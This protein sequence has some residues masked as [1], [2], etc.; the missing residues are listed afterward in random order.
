MPNQ[1][2]VI[3]GKKRESEIVILFVTITLNALKKK[4]KKISL[5]GYVLHTN[6]FISSI[7]DIFGFSL[8]GLKIISQSRCQTFFLS[9]FMQCRSTKH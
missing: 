4:K 3:F 6:S 7:Y 9:T 2:L 8:I 5:F 1:S